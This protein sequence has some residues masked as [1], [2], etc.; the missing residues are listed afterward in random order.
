MTNSDLSKPKPIIISEGDI[1]MSVQT[2][3][4]VFPIR[5]RV[6]ESYWQQGCNDGRAK[7]PPFPPIFLEP[8]IS[9]RN[10]GYTN[11]WHYG[12]AQQ[13]REDEGH[14]RLR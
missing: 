1:A 12:R 5:S 13:F 4:F 6:S 9:L 2:L 11:G 14:D 7:K 3:D 8:L 10:S